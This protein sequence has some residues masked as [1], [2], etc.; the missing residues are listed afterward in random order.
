MNLYYK[1]KWKIKDAYWDFRKRCQRFKRGYSWGDVW[2]MDCWFV[3]VVK[4]MLIHLRTHG[5]TFPTEFNNR[6]EWCA[7]RDEM[8]AGLEFMEEDKVYAFLGFI[9]CDDYW[10]MTAED[11]KAA[12]AM[13]EN[14][15]NRFFELFSK[16]F[17][18]LWD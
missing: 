9:E 11:I 8:I 7:G 12:Y 3:E 16:H 5:E 14:N 10:H 4:P 6:D 15:K 13:R 18:D 2:D 17:Y 1:I